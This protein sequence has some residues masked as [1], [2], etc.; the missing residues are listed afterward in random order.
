MIL[1]SPL[2]AGLIAGFGTLVTG[3]FA[4]KV[5]NLQKSNEKINAAVS[6]LFEIRTAE[7]KIDIISEKLNTNSNTDLPS[8]LPTNN[9]KN[10]SHLFAKDFD[11]DEFKLMNAFYSSCEIIQDLVSRQNNFL[12]IATEERG[13]V[14]QQ[15]LG[16]IYLEHQKDAIVDRTKADEKFTRE[17]DAIT[18]F[19]TDEAYFYTPVKTLNGLKF[20]IENLQ[21]ITPTT[22]AVK[23]KKLAEVL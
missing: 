17:K 5:F 20:Q 21:K 15:L 11:E 8:V 9:W 16:D 23:L 4:I 14:L 7:N 22:C 18:K 12:W 13:R 6:I 10:Y 3:W 19:Y 1:N 2:F